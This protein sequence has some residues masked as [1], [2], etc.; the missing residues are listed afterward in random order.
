MHKFF[1]TL[2]LIALL[3]IAVMAEEHHKHKEHEGHEGHEGHHGHD[4]QSDSEDDECHSCVRSLHQVIE[5]V[6]MSDLEQSFEEA[7]KQLPEE[8][9]ALLMQKAE[10]ILTVLRSHSE[11]SNPGFLCTAVLNVPE[12]AVCA[13]PSQIMCGASCDDAKVRP[14]CMAERWVCPAPSLRACPI[15]PGGD[16]GHDGSKHHHHKGGD[17]KHHG[18]EHNRY[19]HP[20]VSKWTAIAAGVALSAVFCV[21]TCCVWTRCR[22]RHQRRAAQKQLQSDLELISVCKGDVAS[23]KSELACPSTYVPA[24]MSGKQSQAYEPMMVP[25]AQY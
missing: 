6:D 11:F 23:N 22:A 20:H 25:S 18:G 14:M 13:Q 2:A 24:V 16:D 17:N 1:I 5:S 3:A 15:A 7:V 9:Q 4:G 21:C 12:C 19:A 8:T 10:A